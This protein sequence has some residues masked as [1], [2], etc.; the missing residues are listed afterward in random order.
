M[1]T[2]TSLRIMIADDYPI[3]RRG[4]IEEINDQQDMHVVAEAT[5]GHEAVHMYKEF[6]PDVSLIDLRM[7]GLDGIGA[8]GKICA[9]D[10]SAKA[11]VLSTT[12]GDV[13]VARAFQAGARNYLLKNM[14]RKELTS[15]IRTVSRGQRQVPPEVADALVEYALNDSLSDREISVLQEASYGNSN[16]MIADHLQLSEHTVKTHFKNIFSKLHANDRTHAVTIALRR[17]FFNLRIE[18]QRVSP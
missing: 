16:K 1:Q 13:W 7:P 8:I 15:T 5:N 2:S 6:K 14:A 17:G 18:K 10:S 4:L 9:M 3:L 12:I 11:I